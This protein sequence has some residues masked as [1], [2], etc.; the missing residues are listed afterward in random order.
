MSG[1]MRQYIPALVRDYVLQGRLPGPGQGS[2]S[3]WKKLI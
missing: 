1:S 2:I 3:V